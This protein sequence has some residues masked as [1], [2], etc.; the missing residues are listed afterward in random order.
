MILADINDRSDE[1]NA[2][3]RQSA[4]ALEKYDYRPIFT[5]RDFGVG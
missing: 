2:L 3:A 5:I 4:A 1:A